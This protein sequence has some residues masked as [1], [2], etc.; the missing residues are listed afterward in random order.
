MFYP[1]KGKMSPVE[2]RGLTKADKKAKLVS[3][4]G[5]KVLGLSSLLVL[6]LLSALL[7]SPLKAAAGG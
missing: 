1:F 5:L 6:T 4:K 7:W 3:M 2:F